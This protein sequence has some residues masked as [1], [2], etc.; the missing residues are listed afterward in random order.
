MTENE[1]L[2]QTS[3]SFYLTLRLLPRSVRPEICLGYLLARAT[4]TIT[5]SSLAGRNQRLE[6]LHVARRSIGHD[7]IAGYIA[8]N[9]TVPQLT[10]GEN[11]LL[12]R[13]PT[14]WRRMNRLTLPERQ[15]LEVVIDHI[16]EGQIFD[17]EYFND[18]SA[19]L[20]HEELEHYTYL[21]A[22]SVG[23]FWTRI[24]TEKIRPFSSDPMEVMLQRGR[25][26]GQALQLINILRD[27]HAD[28]TLGRNYIHTNDV[29]HWLVMAR[30]WLAE[31]TPYCMALHSGRLRYV[32]LLPALLGW[33]TLRL[34]ETHLDHP[35]A[36]NKVSRCEV[37][38][39]MFRSLT[40]W[41]SSKAIPSLVRAAM[42]NK[43]PTQQPLE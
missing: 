17:L 25:H 38:Q 33:R 21:V 41:G 29:A 6:I 10:A 23:E 42:I 7:E 32:T 30:R 16:L 5:D 39:W 28:A 11:H 35:A 36:V 13:L 26:Y 43:E 9:W 27:R 34:I 3:R 1:I 12:T 24:G 40:A 20:T 14:L 4:D 37:R 15:F 8:N 19:A 22:G 18:R 31:A 2:R